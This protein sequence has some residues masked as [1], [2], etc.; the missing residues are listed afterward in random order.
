MRTVHNILVLKV[1]GLK[2]FL[3]RIEHVLQARAHTNHFPNLA[4]NLIFDYSFRA[5]PEHRKCSYVLS[6]IHFFFYLITMVSPHNFFQ[7][8]LFGAA[9]VDSSLHSYSRNLG[10][11]GIKRL[12]LRG[13]VGAPL[14]VGAP[15]YDDEIDP[16]TIM[17][18][19]LSKKEIK[20]TPKPSRME[21]PGS[22]PDIKSAI[23]ELNHD[24][25]IF[26]GEGDHRW[27]D[28]MTLP[29]D[30]DTEIYVRIYGVKG[31]RLLGRWILPS[32]EI[33]C[34]FAYGSFQDV[35]CAYAT[36]EYL[37][38]DY[39]PNAVFSIMGGPWIY[40]ACEVRAASADAIVTLDQANTTFEHCQV[41]GMGQ[42]WLLNGT[43]GAVN[44]IHGGGNSWTRISS[45]T[46]EFCGIWGGTALRFIEDA[47]CI[48][49]N[50]S[51]K[52]SMLGLG[53]NDG[54]R[55]QVVLCLF[56]DNQFANLVALQN[57]S[58][59]HLELSNNRIHEGKEYM[60][61]CCWA[62]SARPGT[63]IEKDNKII[64]GFSLNHD[65]DW[66]TYHEDI[67]EDQWE[68]HPDLVRLD[69]IED[70]MESMRSQTGNRNG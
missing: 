24:H 11:I 45:C 65:D 60:Q 32:C 40:T 14:E 3:L 56:R 1:A 18:P 51:L 59:V 20:Q 19:A 41:G 28:Y 42:P 2:F 48:L 27:E 5:R 62:G 25:E 35:I 34:S 44:G 13:G 57:S 17:Y 9:I 58:G 7:I 54:S 4:C 43:M 26:V 12:Q 68:T 63:L 69:E 31:T 15:G 70:Y 55:V 66:F 16:W 22:H 29:F 30:L 67:P 21:I 10:K 6:A 64:Q 52:S 47:T 49:H 61:G 33:A 8:I 36:S 53:L 38:E 37:S 46:I 39:K 23:D 50:S